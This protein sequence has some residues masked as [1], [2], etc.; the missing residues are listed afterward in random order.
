MTFL[1]DRGKG[2]S[3]LKADLLKRAKLFQ[4]DP[5]IT[6]RA[7]PCDV[8]SD[9]IQKRSIFSDDSVTWQDVG[10]LDHN[11]IPSNFNLDAVSQYL[12]EIF[13]EVEDDIVSSGTSKP[14]VKGRQMYASGKVILCETAEFQNKLL[15]RAMVDASMKKLVR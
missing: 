4:N 8:S 6:S 13:L 11:R 3:G 7:E 5:V 12:T 10:T 14:A 9:L 2:V 1:R 15:F